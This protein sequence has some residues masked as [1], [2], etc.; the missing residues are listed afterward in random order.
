[1]HCISV[2]PSLAIMAGLF[3][4]STCDIKSEAYALLGNICQ[5]LPN[6]DESGLAIECKFFMDFSKKVF[7]LTYLSIAQYN[8]RVNDINNKHLL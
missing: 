3:D 1:M 6:L 2:E 5:F 4:N 7:I 8:Y